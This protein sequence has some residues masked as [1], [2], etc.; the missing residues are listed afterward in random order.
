MTIRNI[1]VTCQKETPVS[2]I[3]KHLKNIKPGDCIQIE[4]FILNDG[5]EL[6]VEGVESLFQ[7][8]HDGRVYVTWT[9]STSWKTNVIVLYADNV[10]DEDYEEA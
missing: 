2:A 5:T 3:K 9:D 6:P 1:I 7:R 8:I 10:T 4:N